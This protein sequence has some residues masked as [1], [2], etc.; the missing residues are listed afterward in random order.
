MSVHVTP[1]TDELLTRPKKANLPLSR[2]AYIRCSWGPPGIHTAAYSAHRDM[3]RTCSR[4][5]EKEEDML[6]HVPENT[7]A[8]DSMG[9]LHEGTAELSLSCQFLESQ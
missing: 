4:R 9:I 3:D 2:H 8:S 1:L 7:N 5:R 6:A